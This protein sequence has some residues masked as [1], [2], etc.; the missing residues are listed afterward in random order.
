[1][2]LRTLANRRR[3]TVRA[4]DQR[5]PLRHLG[6][7]VHEDRALL[8]ER[9]DDVSVVDDLMAHID[10]GTESLER[11]LDDRDRAIYAGAEATRACEENLH[12]RRD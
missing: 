2:E 7:I 5:R 6:R 12:D 3:H 4:E 1:M 10:R 9:I 11:P 8:L